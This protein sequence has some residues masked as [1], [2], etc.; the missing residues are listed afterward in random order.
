MVLALNN[1]V[2][3]LVALFIRYKVQFAD[4]VRLSFVHIFHALVEGS[5]AGTMKSGIA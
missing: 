1:G 5:I 3:F 2:S 4:H